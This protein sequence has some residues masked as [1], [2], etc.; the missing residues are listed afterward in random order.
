MDDQEIRIMAKLLNNPDKELSEFARKRLDSL[1][2]SK[3]VQFGRLALVPK[4]IIIANALKRETGEPDELNLLETAAQFGYLQQLPE[5]VKSKE[6]LMSK[7]PYSGDTIFHL[8]ALRGHLDQLPQSLLTQE[9]LVENRSRT[10]WTPISNALVNGL[11]HQ[12][13]AQLLTTENLLRPVGPANDPIIALIA[14]NDKLDQFQGTELSEELKT[15]IGNNWWIKN[16]ETL[17]AKKEVT[18]IEPTT[19][20]EIF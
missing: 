7:S 19:E 4:Q 3:L 14:F 6:L 20:V 13:P 2:L 16:Q 8:A 18:S 17:K 1:D 12:I 5:E 10:N 11:A 9:T 15:Y